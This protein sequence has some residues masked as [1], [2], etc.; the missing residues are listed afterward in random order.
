MTADPVV[1]V[2]DAPDQLDRAI[3]AME[4]GVACLAVELPGDVW[5]DVRDRWHAVRDALQSRPHYPAVGDDICGVCGNVLTRKPPSPGGL[6]LW[7]PCTHPAVGD[8]RLTEENEMLKRALVETEAALNESVPPVEALVERLAGE[9]DALEAEHMHDLATID[10]LAAEL[11]ALT[12]ERDEALKAADDWAAGWRAMESKFSVAQG[13][14]TALAA[15]L[16]ALREALERIAGDELCLIYVP[17][18]TCNTETHTVED[19][20][21]PC[22]PCIAADALAPTPERAEK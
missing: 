17:P 13:E 9:R 14:V 3:A 1:S 18:Y 19:D 6:D 21:G 16:G 22:H 2:T 4:R 7:E 12:R 10:A 5:T 15:E 20:G 8:E 11:G